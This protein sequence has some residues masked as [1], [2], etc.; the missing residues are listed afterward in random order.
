[1]KL[2]RHI[3][4]AYTNRWFILTSVILRPRTQILWTR[5][6]VSSNF[7][8]DGPKLSASI[9]RWPFQISSW[10]FSNQRKKEQ[11]K[12]CT[13]PIFEFRHVAIWGIRQSRK[14]SVSRKLR[15]EFRWKS[16]YVVTFWYSFSW[17]YQ[18]LKNPNLKKSIFLKILPICTCKIEKIR[19]FSHPILKSI[20]IEG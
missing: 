11:R 3:N 18:K 1:M 13:G 14:L 10:V 19:K 20:I 6:T 5:G 16:S 8:L 9:A 4:S 2:C 7:F 15:N 12:K 17:E